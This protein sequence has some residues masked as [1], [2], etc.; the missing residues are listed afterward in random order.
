MYRLMTKERVLKIILSIVVLLG[1]SQMSFVVL[2]LLG[3]NTI[4]DKIAHWILNHI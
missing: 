2:D 4:N 3:F 1:I